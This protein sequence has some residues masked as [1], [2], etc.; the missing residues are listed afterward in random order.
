MPQDR[1]RKFSEENKELAQ[2][3]KKEMDALRQRSAPKATASNKKKNAGSDLSSTRGSE[4]RHS[5][6][7]VTGRG[8][9]RG[10]DYE[11][12]KVCV[13]QFTI[14]AL[15]EPLPESGTL[16]A[17]STK[18]S[19]NPFTGPSSPPSSE[20]RVK[21]PIFTDG[22]AD[23]PPGLSAA[24]TASPNMG[25]SSSTLSAPP[26]SPTASP[27]G[28]VAGIKVAEEISAV[29]GPSSVAPEE[30]T[31]IEK[32]VAVQLTLEGEA[33]LQ[34]QVKREAKRLRTR[35]TTVMEPTK[36]IIDSLENM[37]SDAKATTEKG[38]PLLDPT[39]GILEPKPEPPAKRQRG[40][41]GAV[42]PL[43]IPKPK[44][45]KPAQQAPKRKLA[46]VAEEEPEAPAK[47]QRGSMGLK[48]GPDPKSQEPKEDTLVPKTAPCDTSKRN[49]G[50]N[51]VAKLSASPQEDAFTN[52]L[53]VKI[54]I[55][56]NL[57][58]ILVDD[59][60]QVTKNQS[61]LPLPVPHPVNEIMDL[62]CTQELA[63]RRPGS[64]EYD[65]L[66]ETVHGIKE[67]FAKCLGKILLYKLEREQYYEMRACW[68][69]SIKE[70]EGKGPGDIYGAEHLIR[71]FCESHL[72]SYAIPLG[73]PPQPNHLPFVPPHLLTRLTPAAPRS[74]IPP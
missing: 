36:S 4:E 35:A 32:E 61:M 48:S 66:E 25:G 30:D 20:A 19:T 21:W 2:N 51:K 10:R 8:Q 12:E 56:D 27:G 1:L 29:A 11:I 38:K 52:K 47:R 7:P 41:R 58:S 9:K 60:E 13:E 74:S 23:T 39:I 73:T 42:V 26:A 14:R 69:G 31:G 68:E 67:Y 63:K 43:E 5:S 24:G 71:L 17:T 50:K 62:Y 55:P 15:S 57:K 22:G 45:G 44:P 59:W 53:A 49:D 72:P 33:R 54:P 37:S 65:I 16:Y 6:V 18:G 28:A 46:S 70:W 3:L 64:A 34:D 40:R